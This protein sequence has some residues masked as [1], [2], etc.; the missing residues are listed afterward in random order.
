MSR[1]KQLRPFRVQDDDEQRTSEANDPT[2]VRPLQDTNGYACDD[3]SDTS[4]GN[5]NEIIYSI[6][7]N[8]ACVGVALE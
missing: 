8:V 6:N 1:R 4:N 7:S 5:D 2:T 3:I